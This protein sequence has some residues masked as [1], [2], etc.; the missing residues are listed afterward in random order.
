MQ[1]IDKKQ[2]HEKIVAGKKGVQTETIKIKIGK[3]DV[4]MPKRCHACMISEEV[5]FAHY[6]TTSVGKEPEAHSL[7]IL[8][9]KSRFLF[10]SGV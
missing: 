8:N 1:G 5:L 3:K 4:T 7:L 9:K 10:L 2:K 6:R